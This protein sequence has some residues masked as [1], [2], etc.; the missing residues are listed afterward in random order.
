MP[1]NDH[2]SSLDIVEQR[3][4][5]LTRPP[6]ALSLDCA[7]L[8]CGLP[9]RLICLDE[10]RVLLLKVRTAWV[11]KDAV[12]KE[13]ARRAHTEPDPWVMAAAGMLLPGLK[14]IAGRLS[15]QYPGDNQDL[16]S[17]ILGGFFEALDLVEADHPKVYSQLYMGAFRRG[18]EACC[19]ERRLAAKRAELDEG[20]VDTYRARQEGHP[21]LLLA[22][23]V[24]DKAL[25][26]EQA[27]LLSDVHLGGMN[28]TCAAAALGVTPRRC[29]AQLAQAQRKL[30]GFLA[31]RVPDIAS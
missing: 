3:F 9:E 8:G 4:V 2:P 6:I 27:G 31:E 17:E 10:L 1:Y 24:L 14:R 11:T 21:D 18:H 19:R 22:N 20:R 7:T 16:D 12:W 5:E 25:T 13:L 28:C 23:A 26:A 29:R 30:V 15:R